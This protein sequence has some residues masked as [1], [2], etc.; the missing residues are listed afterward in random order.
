MHPIAVSKKGGIKMCEFKVGDE[1]HFN[2]Y[3]TDDYIVKHG[4]ISKFEQSL[5]PER[6]YAVIYCDNG[7]S[8]TE[9]H[10]FPED[11]YCTEQE[12][13]EVLKKRF[14]FEVDEV[15]KNI[16]TLEDLLKF[17]YNNDVSVDED[18]DDCVWEERVAVRE[19]AK[20]ICGIELGE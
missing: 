13:K 14:R 9:Y 19:L 6:K 11:L 18:D 3:S 4:K 10:I 5:D 2:P 7:R 1:V 17:L 16:H 20:E 8:M 15:K 12:V